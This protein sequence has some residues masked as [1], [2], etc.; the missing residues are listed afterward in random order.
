LRDLAN[1]GATLIDPGPEGA[2]FEDAIADVLPSLDAPAPAAVFAEAF[3]P[4]TDLVEK[5]VAIAGKAAFDALVYPTKTVLA[6]R[7]AAPGRRVTAV[8]KGTWWDCCDAQSVAGSGQSLPIQSERPCPDWPA[9]DSEGALI[10][11]Y[12]TGCA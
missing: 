8:T 2:L 11:S 3:P 10:R 12:R 9:A 5:S 6:P 7:L 4:G 1:A